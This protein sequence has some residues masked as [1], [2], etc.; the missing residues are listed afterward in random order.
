MAK[1]T[2]GDFHSLKE[3]TNELDRLDDVGFAKL[4]Q[5]SRNWCIRNSRSGDEEE[6]LQ[7]AIL[8][9]LKSGITG[10]RQ[11]PKGVPF[12]DFLSGVMRSIASDRA[13][14][15]FRRNF[16]KGIEAAE[17]IASSCSQEGQLFEE[18]FMARFMVLFEEDDDAQLYLLAL[19]EGQTKSEIMADFDWN[20]RKYNAVLQR[21]K[22]KRAAH[23]ELK[24][25]LY[26][27]R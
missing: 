22:R 14:I 15:G 10:T 27:E 11:W 7:E 8:R 18:Q 19:E 17:D 24:E 26:G 13:K 3:F 2:S 1:D 4:L 6:V 12:A 5:R 23:P 9:I 21:I 16:D 25:M 20:E